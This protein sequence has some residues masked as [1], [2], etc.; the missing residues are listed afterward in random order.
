MRVRGRIP[1]N[2]VGRGWRVRLAASWP[3][4]P[5]HRAP[6]KGAD[7][8]AA[9]MHKDPNLRKRNALVIP[10][11]LLAV[12]GFLGIVYVHF[13]RGSD[14]SCSDAGLVV[15]PGACRSAALLLAIP[16]IVGLALG[17]AGALAYRSKATCR[18]GHGSWTHFGLALLLS[19]VVVPL[20]GL[21]LSPSLVGS[22]AT[23][24]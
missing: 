12:Y 22:G 1:P 16:L 10:G 15:F 8:W 21:V 19:M 23:V 20:L 6:F 7:Q 17:A 24:V 4:L 14:N 5:A 11:G 18:H 9:S 3:R 2:K 13:L